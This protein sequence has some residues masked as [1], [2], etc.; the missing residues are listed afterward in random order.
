M[1]RIEWRDKWIN[2]LID[3]GFSPSTARDTYQAM[4]GRDG[5]DLSKNAAQ[6]AKAMLGKLN[7]T[8][9]FHTADQE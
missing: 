3:A 1:M 6:E 5:P 7:P 8:E 2:T 9:G 4:Y